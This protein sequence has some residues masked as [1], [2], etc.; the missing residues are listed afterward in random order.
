M[1]LI[2]LLTALGAITWFQYGDL[3]AYRRLKTLSDTAFRQRI[4]QLITNNQDKINAILDEYGVPLQDQRG[5]ALH[6]AQ[7][8]ATPR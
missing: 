2:L 7:R 4:D 5:Q 1:P 3:G 8:P 6:M